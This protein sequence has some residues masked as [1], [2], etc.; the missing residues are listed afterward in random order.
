MFRMRNAKYL[1][2]KIAVISAACL[3]PIQTVLAEEA[4]PI[5]ASPVAATSTTLPQAMPQA[6]PPTAT[7]GGTLKLTNEYTFTLNSVTGPGAASSNLPRG[8]H[9]KDIFTFDLDNKKNNKGLSMNFGLNVTDDIT[10]DPK[11]LS[12]VSFA[13]KYDDEKQNIV[14]GDTMSS[15]S[16]YSMS[17]SLKGISYHYQDENKTG[18]ELNLVY[19]RQYA[20]WDNFWDNDPA[21]QSTPRMA[22]G[23][24]L[25][26]TLGD[27]FTLGF[28]AV[29]T[30][31]LWRLNSSTTLYNTYVC[32][33]DWEYKPTS[34]WTYNGEYARSMS[35]QSVSDDMGYTSQ[36]GN[37]F[38][39]SGVGEK[40]KRRVALDYERVTPN[41]LTQMGSAGADR[42]K[43]KVAW[44]DRLGLGS[45]YHTIVY[46]DRNN[47]ANQLTDSTQNINYDIGTTFAQPFGRENGTFDISLTRNREHDTAA[48]NVLDKTINFE[49]KDNVCG[50]DADATVGYMR[51]DTA[52]TSTQY[53]WTHN[54]TL[55]SSLARGQTTII[56]TLTI[57][58]S[59]QY[60][61][62]S[63]I[64]Q[65]MT[66]EYS[67]G[68]TINFAGG[69]SLALTTGWEK[70]DNYGSS[71]NTNNWFTTLNWTFKP[72]FLKK[73]VGSS[74]YLKVGIHDYSFSNN[75]SNYR[76]NSIGMG[77]KC[78]F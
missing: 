32:S 27:D 42:E 29:R 51:T 12:L 23:M 59:K 44:Q 36:S 14:A 11:R 71:D 68:A 28:N 3:L 57:A 55:S 60:L 52:N 78:E 18:P 62:A 41:F 5:T 75:N 39:F 7:A 77:V 70:A 38:R 53:N 19:G 16:T 40:G 1:Q 24:R 47:L 9:F 21:T 34:F 65:V 67:L 72:S 4:E 49:Y 46:W 54:L 20:R 13:L 35:S 43:I 37:A 33:T 61:L 2:L 26:Q 48:T 58:H 69:D 50:M 22:E 17:S 73:F 6:N 76:E 66:R 25:K 64:S 15:Y 30:D 45:I 10:V 8:S 56:P 31:D 74:M 63:D